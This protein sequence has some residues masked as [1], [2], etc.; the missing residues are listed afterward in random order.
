MF[1]AIFS[2]LSYVSHVCFYEVSADQCAPGSEENYGP[3]NYAEFGK[4]SSNFSQNLKI[5]VAG[6]IDYT[7]NLSSIA[8]NTSLTIVGVLPEKNSISI[9]NDCSEFRMNIKNLTINVPNE[10]EILSFSRILLT[11]TIFSSKDTF[12]F[13][14]DNA[15]IDFNSLI[16]IPYSNFGYLRISAN[17]FDMPNIPNITYSVETAKVDI[18]NFKTDMS[19]GAFHD[20]YLFWKDPRNFISLRFYKNASIS[21]MQFDDSSIVSFSYLLSRI[22]YYYEEKVSIVVGSNSKIKFAASNYPINEETIY[23]SNY[24]GYVSAYDSSTIYL[25]A[26]RIPVIISTNGNVNFVLCNESVVIPD[27][28]IFVEGRL[29]VKSIIQKPAKLSVSSVYLNGDVTINVDNNITLYSD[30]FWS[31]TE[32]NYIYLHGEGTYSFFIYF[33]YGNQKIEISNLI[34]EG[35]TVFDVETPAPTT[36]INIKEQCTNKN[37][38]FLIYCADFKPENETENSFSLLQIKGKSFDYDIPMY[39]KGD[40]VNKQYTKG[41]TFPSINKKDEQTGYIAELS[42]MVLADDVHDSFCFAENESSCSNKYHYLSDYR[43]F[44]GYKEDELDNLHFYV[45]PGFMMNNTVSFM[46]YSKRG[47]LLEVEVKGAG[48]KFIFDGTYFNVFENLTIEELNCTVKS[49]ISSSNLHQVKLSNTIL[50]QELEKAV[51]K[52]RFL[53]ADY[54]TLMSF[55]ETKIQANIT[56]HTYGN[57]VTITDN[58]VLIGNKSFV[59]KN[60]VINPDGFDLEIIGQSTTS[61]V[62]ISIAGTPPTFTI[63]GVFPPKFIIALKVPIEKIVTKIEEPPISLVTKTHL[64]IE[65]DLKHVLINNDVIIQNSTQV[66]MPEGSEIHF[67]R[68]GLTGAGNI[69]TSNNVS[70][71]IDKLIGKT[72]NFKPGHVNYSNIIISYNLGSKVLLED[73]KRKNLSLTMYYQLTSIPEV[74]MKNGNYSTISSVNLVYDSYYPYME[75]KMF[76]SN[77]YPYLKGFPIVCGESLV[78]DTWDIIFKETKYNIS[79]MFYGKCVHNF[80]NGQTCVA[81]FAKPE[82]LPQPPKYVNEKKIILAFTSSALGILIIGAVILIIRVCL[83][84]KE[85]KASYSTLSASFTRL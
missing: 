27:E 25:E 79:K 70:V 72:N 76:A 14:A 45:A 65:S 33:L 35:L 28:Y 74:T 78:C 80:T 64:W 71:I 67:S 31:Y 54:P 43:E 12:Y 41:S 77:P 15:Y 62:Y 59:C 52:A 51:V 1:L 19:I 37:P 42:A 63:S 5:S 60:V 11:K 58:G 13:V 3:S 56:V 17:N 55:T 38:T 46:E 32:K 75:E 49:R 83:K 6:N 36:L 34:F 82:S 69:K 23:D 26:N 7:L 30:T 81:M 44:P 68:I 24:W 10:T 21:F 2:L 48:G 40:I 4:K 22:N 47:S 29:N 61:N 84:K 18:T 85:S 9:P 50:D 57:S 39:I 73:D 66:K 20:T 8:I 53:E 16:S